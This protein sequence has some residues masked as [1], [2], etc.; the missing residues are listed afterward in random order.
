MVTAK[1]YYRYAVPTAPVKI[2]GE[3]LPARDVA[4]TANGTATAKHLRGE[5]IAFLVEA[6]SERFHVGA[7]SSFGGMSSCNVVVRGPLDGGFIR[8]DWEV[9][10]VT[11]MGIF[12][13]FSYVYPHFF[14]AFPSDAYVVPT[15]TVPKDQFPGERLKD[16]DI[17]ANSQEVVDLIQASIQDGILRNDYL[18][19]YFYTLPI[20]TKFGVYGASGISSGLSYDVIAEG[21]YTIP[22][23]VSGSGTHPD[24]P[25]DPNQSA[26]IYSYYMR[27][28]IHPSITRTQTYER[29]I[30]DS[31]SAGISYSYDNLVQNSVP[32]DIDRAR[33]VVYVRIDA[34][35][36][37]T[38][39]GVVQREESASY[40]FRAET[41]FDDINAAF[42]D[43]AKL[44]SMMDSA[45]SMSGITKEHPASSGN[46]DQQITVTAGGPS[47]AFGS[48]GAHTDITQIGWQWTP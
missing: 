34:T 30:Q 46:W 37:I 9:R 8:P 4:D 21:E 12:Y 16:Y 32:V 40:L 10:D 28:E 45:L 43:S 23:G 27:S 47:F 20:I 36:K 19:H 26:N 39:D 15:S 6:L 24:V 35:N 18:R 11:I 25:S 29:S 38:L 1:Q 5:D 48:L 7:S 17:P 13:M 3:I 33:A 14:R 22:E 44:K 2:N 42:V 41:V 31:A